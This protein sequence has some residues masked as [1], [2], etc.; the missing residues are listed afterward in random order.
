MLSGVNKRQGELEIPNITMN[1]NRSTPLLD[2]HIAFVKQH[3]SLWVLPA[4]VLAVGLRFYEPIR[5]Y[6]DLVFG[7]LSNIIESIIGKFT[8][9]IRPTL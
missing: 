1:E 4:G 8:D 2:Q 3:S 5:E 6:I 9:L 7:L